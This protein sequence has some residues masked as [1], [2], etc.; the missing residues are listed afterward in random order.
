LSRKPF[1]CH[2]IDQIEDFSNEKPTDVRHFLTEKLKVF[3]SPKNHIDKRV[4]ILTNRRDVEADLVGLKLLSKGIDYV[5]L[6][7]E[8][9]PSQLQIKYTITQ[10]SDLK[11]EF[12]IRQESWEP[13]DVSVV[14]LRHFDLQSINFGDDDFIRKFSLQQWD[15]AYRTLRRTL[16]CRWIS[17]PSATLKADDRIKQL[18]VAK[19]LGL[20][21]PSTLITNDPVAASAFY[22]SHHGDIVIKALHHH[23]IESNNKRY[24]IYTHR[25]KEVDFPLFNDLIY[26]PCILQERLDKKGE[27][28]A[29]VIGDKVFAAEIE[30]QSTTMGEEDFHRCPLS[31]LAIIPIKLDNAVAEQCIRIVDSFGL[32]CG[33]IDFVINDNDSLTFLEVNAIGDWY[34]IESGTGLPITEAVVDLISKYV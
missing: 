16:T 22:Q 21:I 28:R 26:A 30:P 19:S 31:E 6:N 11:T 9:I 32:K 15:N 17:S 10:A 13:S 7:I 33:S 4:L 34:W 2:F 12:C 23:C 5:R 14:W 25:M 24:S 29:S 8:D 18:S 27:I 3:P 20:D 1:L